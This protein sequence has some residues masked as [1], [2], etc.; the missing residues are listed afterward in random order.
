MML[1]SSRRPFGGVGAGV[2]GAM[3]GD[4]VTAQP[5]NLAVARGGYLGLHIEVARERGGGEILDAI[6]GPFHRP[7]GDDRSDDRTDIAGIGADLVAETAAD[8][9][10]DDMDLVLGDFRDQRAD[11]ANDVRR[12]ERA[13]KRQL[14][15]DLV[16]GGDALAGLERARMYARIN[17]HLLD[18]D[19]GL[20]ER[21][22]SRG[23]VARLPGEDVVIV[24]A[25]AVGAVGLILQIFANHRRIRRHRL[26]RIDID[27]QRLVFDFHQIGGIGRDIAILGDHERHFL[28]LEQH[29]AVGEH[30]LD[31][32]RQRRHPGEIDGFQRFGGEHRDDAGD[33]GGFAGIDLLD[34]G[35][36][37]RRAIEIAVEH[38]RQLQIVD[39]VAFALDE[40]DILDALSPATH[41]FEFF[42][43][44]SGG[45]GLSVHSAASW[46][47]T[48]LS[49]A[50]AN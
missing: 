22:V 26:E 2:E 47:A 5:R 43:A 14:A 37:M 4:G 29:L 16:E 35:V 11:R 33:G 44:F 42:G 34:T 7:A 48:P 19:L 41:A 8:I 13:P 38:A 46:K 23:L 21:G 36:R 28:I 12:L 40:A 9:R 31:V 3:V 39:V 27:R 49:F 45:G 50:A 15:F 20:V 18:L 25:L 30:H 1:K 32:A 6:L 17:D 24:L 10:R